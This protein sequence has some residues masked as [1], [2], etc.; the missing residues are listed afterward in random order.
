MLKL[1]DVLVVE[2]LENLRFLS[3]QV[4]IVLVQILPSDDLQLI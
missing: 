1:D 3:Q 2:G 4:Y